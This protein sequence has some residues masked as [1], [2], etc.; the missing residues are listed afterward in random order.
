[1]REKQIK[2]ASTK[3]QEGNDPS[4]PKTASAIRGYTIVSLPLLNLLL[5]M[6]AI[7][8]NVG[9]SGENLGVE[10]G[11]YAM[12]ND[13]V[14][15]FARGILQFPGLLSFQSIA[16]LG[17]AHEINEVK[18]YDTS[19]RTNSKSMQ[20]E[21]TLISAPLS[22]KLIGRVESTGVNISF[23]QIRFKA[24]FVFGFDIL[25]LTIH[26]QSRLFPEPGTS[27][28]SLRDKSPGGSLRVG[29]AFIGVFF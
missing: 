23:G 1:V 20:R 28:E 8:L 25:D 21:Y 24:P 26:I 29:S 16:R 6:P 22:K 12:A 7:G 11:G 27:E 15:G 10:L 9:V 13:T 5:L 19:T 17:V 2:T 18:I 4:P 3:P 14:G